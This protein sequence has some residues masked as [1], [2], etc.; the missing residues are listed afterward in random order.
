MILILSTVSDELLYYEFVKPLERIIS[1]I[2]SYDVVNYMENY[3][4]FKYDKVV[5]SGTAIKDFGY[6]DKLDRFNWIL[7]YN[8]NIVGI[9]AGSQIIARLYGMELIDREI[10]GIKH[11]KCRDYGY[12][13]KFLAYFIITKIPQYNSNV[14]P[15]CLLENGLPVGF[16]ILGT[17]KYG[18]LFHPEVYNEPLLT[19]ILFKI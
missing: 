9:C 3:D 17:N 18:F 13:S 5:I 2:D 4:P 7:N 15:L 19:S 14:D 1:K 12:G 16:K 11:V 10:I 8:K 6:L